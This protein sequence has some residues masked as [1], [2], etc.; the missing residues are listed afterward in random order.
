MMA[1]SRLTPD[2]VE[3]SSAAHIH[4]WHRRES[5]SVLVDA[6]S[7]AD[8]NENGLHLCRPLMDWCGRYPSVWIPLSDR[9]VQAGYTLR[10]VDQ[11]VPDGKT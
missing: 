1:A 8:Q 7:G 2:S 11:E 9:L 4:G 3:T 10:S 5:D 6:A